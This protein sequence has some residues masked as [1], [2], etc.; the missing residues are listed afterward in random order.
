MKPREHARK[1]ARQM[2]REGIPW[3]HAKRQAGVLTAKNNPH[4]GGMREAT[5]Q[6]IEDYA[7]RKAS[8]YAA[9]RIR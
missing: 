8:L 7:K 9:R 1:M 5:P 4:L 3:D 2:Q 6:E